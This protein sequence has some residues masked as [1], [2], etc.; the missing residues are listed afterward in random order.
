[1]LQTASHA[2]HVCFFRNIENPHTARDEGRPLVLRNKEPLAGRPGSQ[3]CLRLLGVEPC[4]SSPPKP[5]ITNSPCLSLSTAVPSLPD[6]PS[7]PGSAPKTPP[8]SRSAAVETER[9]SGSGRVR[10]PAIGAGEG[11]R[12]HTSRSEA[13]ARG[14]AMLGLGGRRWGGDAGGRSEGIR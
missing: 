4:L 6:H 7:C 14:E 9:S 3:K 13:S 2:V 11:Q 5:G 1:M 10:L 12:I 8:R